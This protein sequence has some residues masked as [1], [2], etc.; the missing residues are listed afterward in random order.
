MPARL[1]AL[2]DKC[3]GAEG[4]RSTGL[5]GRRDGRPDLAARAAQPIDRIGRRKSERERND[6][7]RVVDQDGNLRVELVVVEAR[8][9][10]RR[11]EALGL[12]RE[13]SDV[14]GVGVVW[15]RLTCDHEEIDRDRL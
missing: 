11:A 14:V 4:R 3:V 1:A 5:V 7:D 13:R 8:L 10:N 12:A 9:A 2:D 15:R 6:F